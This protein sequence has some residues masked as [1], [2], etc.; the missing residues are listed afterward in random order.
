MLK[1]MDGWIN[2]KT[3]TVV[4]YGTKGQSVGWGSRGQTSLNTLFCRFNFGT[5]VNILHNYIFKNEIKKKKKLK[6]KLFYIIRNKNVIE[7]KAD[8]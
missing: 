7:L 6:E 5:H 3:N 8:L 2:H 1:I 4:I